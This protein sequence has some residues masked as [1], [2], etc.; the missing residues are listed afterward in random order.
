MAESASK[1]K[2]CSI[3]HARKCG[4]DIQ[5]VEVEQELK[6]CTGDEVTTENFTVDV[7]D[8]GAN[9]EEMKRDEFI[10]SVLTKVDVIKQAHKETNEKHVTAAKDIWDNVNNMNSKQ[11]QNAT[12][13]QVNTM[14]AKNNDKDKNP[15]LFINFV[16]GYV[17][18]WKTY[19]EPSELLK[20]TPQNNWTSMY[21]DYIK[22]VMIAYL[23]IPER[24]MIDKNLT[25]EQYDKR[26]LEQICA[27]AY[28]AIQSLNN[29]YAEFSY[30]ANKDLVVMMFA[31]HYFMNPP[32]DGVVPSQENLLALKVDGEKS[33]ELAEGKSGSLFGTS[34]NPELTEF[35][36]DLKK[37]YKGT[38]TRG[39][40]KGRKKQSG[41][42]GHRTKE[43][44][45]QVCRL[46][47]LP[48]DGTMTQ[49][50]D[51][52]NGALAASVRLRVGP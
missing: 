9:R 5:V 20:E 12:V 35:M 10:T 38:T 36:T 37:F 46:L 13:S 19:M 33:L 45:V 22:A 43:D 15:L 41:G 51:R 52:I 39:S 27:Y 3:Y 2:P 14:L 24:L 40:A 25:L 1:K 48:L 7:C 6:K 42:G 47:D 49:L 16:L 26:A 18:E 32:K 34:P 31:M 11:H 50:R 21:I 30:E 8:N 23:G 28:I 4:E 17:S 29:Q 44:L